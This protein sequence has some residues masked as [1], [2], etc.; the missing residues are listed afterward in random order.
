[1]IEHIE[2]RMKELQAEKQELAEFQALDKVVLYY[3]SP[4]RPD[5]TPFGTTCA[6]IDMSE[7]SLNLTGC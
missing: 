7:M 6:Q 4:C 2:K 5:H 1:M 3:N